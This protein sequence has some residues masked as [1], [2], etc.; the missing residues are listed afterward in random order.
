[1]PSFL[2]DFLS[3]PVSVLGLFMD[4][5]MITQEKNTW[6]IKAWEKLAKLFYLSYFL[7]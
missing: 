2:A 4:E 5:N 7:L 6:R 1:M 3:V